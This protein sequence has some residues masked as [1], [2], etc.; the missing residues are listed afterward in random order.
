MSK[1]K[2]TVITGDKWVGKQGAALLDD[3]RNFLGRFVSYPSEHASVAHALWIGHAHLMASW[4][5]TPRLAFLSPEPGSGKTRALE[6]TEL[7]V[8]RPVNTM[9]AS[10]AYLFRKCGDVEAGPPTILFDEID[11]IFGPKVKTEHEDIRAFVNSGHRRGACFGRCVVHGKTVM[12]E[13]IQSFAPIALAG[14]GWMPDTIVTRSVIIR[15][16]RRRPDEKVEPFRHRVH[17]PAGEELRRRLAEWAGQ[18][19]ERAELAR[20]EMPAG[21]EDRNADVWEPLL[22]V[23]DLVESDWPELARKAAVAF[24]AAS[25]VAPASLN[26]RLLTD[27]RTIFLNNLEEASQAKPEGLPTK[28]VLAELMALDDAPWATLKKPLDA[29]QLSWRLDEYEAG[30][31]NLRPHGGNQ[32]KGY[33]LADLADAWRR[34]L[35]PLPPEAVAAVPNVPREPL[36]RFFEVAPEPVAGT[37]GT[38]GTGF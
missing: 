5:S 38:A 21:I 27:L 16:R 25:H 22:A 20:P 31:K 34:Y 9:N 10:S 13:E 3:V 32:A 30:P 8:P 18:V 12:T 23:A 4:E 36:Q 35:S 2:Y 19:A 29:N 26:V 17:A 1:K 24:V 6:T 14:L 11:S 33:H 15:M 37:A 7:L 28:A